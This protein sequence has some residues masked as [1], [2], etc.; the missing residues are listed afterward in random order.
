M[1]D[2][3]LTPDDEL[4]RTEM[5]QK[6]EFPETMKVLDQVRAAMVERVFATTLDAK[7]ER[8]RLFHA[9]QIVDAMRKPMLE[10]LNSSAGSEA[11]EAFVKEIAEGGS[12]PRA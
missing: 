11:I 4:K 5:A 7:D 6:R 3:T 9:V 10:A 1:T 12:D 8:E 2:E